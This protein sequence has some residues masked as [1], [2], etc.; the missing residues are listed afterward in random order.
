MENNMFNGRVNIMSKNYPGYMECQNTTNGY[1]I[2][3][4]SL[5]H[6]PVSALFFSE[7]NI[8][9]LQ[10]GICNKVFNQT[11][12]KHNIGKQS[13]SEL[14]IIMRS[15]YYESLKNNFPNIINE[16][17]RPNTNIMNTPITQSYDSVLEQVRRLN[18]SVID[19]SVNEII[20]N[21]QQ[22]EKYKADVSMLPR[23]IDRP[24][25]ASKAGTKTLELQS[26]L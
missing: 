14:K 7:K 19:W 5:A 9:A 18:K 8:N 25:M 21:I 3:S 6:T 20:S 1:D 22:F 10:N 16:M 24:I 12:G 26:F 23:P 4:K 13:E 15:F 17:K 11:N 2:V